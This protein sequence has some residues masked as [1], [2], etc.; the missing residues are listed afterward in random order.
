[1]ADLAR[2]HDDHDDGQR[3]C[4]TPRGS[5]ALSRDAATGGGQLPTETCAGKRRGVR[6]PTTGAHDGMDG[7]SPRRGDGGLQTD[8]TG[9]PS[10][11]GSSWSL[12]KPSGEEEGEVSTTAGDVGNGGGVASFSAW[13]QHLQTTAAGTGG[14]G[15]T[16]GQRCGWP[17]PLYRCA[18]DGQHHPARPISRRS[19]AA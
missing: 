9:T 19:V 8:T 4:G 5:P 15:T 17:V 10:N 7:D 16:F 6:R 13:R 2:R 18:R 14:R 12:C 11:G 3:K 1:V